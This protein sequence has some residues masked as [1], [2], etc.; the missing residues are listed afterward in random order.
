[1][2]L[3]YF[4]DNAVSAPSGLNGGETL[5]AILTK[6]GTTYTLSDFNTGDV[7]ASGKAAQLRERIRAIKNI[8][9]K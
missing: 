2:P 3:T 8:R 5:A 1:M 4:S 9:R 6:S 7:L